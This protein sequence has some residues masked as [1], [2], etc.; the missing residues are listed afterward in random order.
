MLFVARSLLRSV[1]VLFLF[2]FLF[3]STFDVVIFYNEG[4]P[5]GSIW[6]TTVIHIEN[7][8]RSSAQFCSFLLSLFFLAQ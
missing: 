3:F 5:L 6:D 4:C 7:I 8:F 1:V 2:R